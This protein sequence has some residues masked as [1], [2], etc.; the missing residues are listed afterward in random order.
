[1]TAQKRATGSITL[2][3]L[4]CY[5]TVIDFIAPVSG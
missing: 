1:M 5:F 2:S 4:S 3:I